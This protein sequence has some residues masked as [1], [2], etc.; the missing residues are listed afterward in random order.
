M[1]TLISLAF[2]YILFCFYMID[3]YF[4]PYDPINIFTYIL[5]LKRDIRYSKYNYYKSS[6]F[7]LLNVFNVYEEIL[8]FRLF[9]MILFKKHLKFLSN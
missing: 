9:T 1:H 2:G 3:F 5:Y 8:E 6:W 4:S 7:N